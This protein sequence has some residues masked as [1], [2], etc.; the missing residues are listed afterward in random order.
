MA[1]GCSIPRPADGVAALGADFARALAAA[2]GIK[3]AGTTFEMNV[4]AI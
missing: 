2:W 4:S 1:D 3:V